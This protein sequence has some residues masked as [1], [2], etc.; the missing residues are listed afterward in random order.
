MINKACH[1]SSYPAEALKCLRQIISSILSHLVNK[2]QNFSVFPNSLKT[3]RVIPLFKSGTTT[4]LT[5]YR[6]ISVL[7]LLSKV[8]EGDVHNQLYFFLEKYKILRLSQSG[9]RSGKSTSLAVMDIVNLVYEKLDSCE[10]H[11]LFSWFRYSVWLSWSFI[12]Y[13]Q[14][15]SIRCMGNSLR[16]V[17]ILP[18]WKEA[19]CIS[20][21]SR[22][23]STFTI[24]WCATKVHSWSLAFLDS[25]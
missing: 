14:T 11:I 24:L 3:A 12:S 8:F 13:K 15:V 18:F 17:E 19:I 5:N 9:F 21:F 4:S 2:S 22:F 6:S 7:P 16:M 20:E 10:S 23:Y 25:Q 1:I